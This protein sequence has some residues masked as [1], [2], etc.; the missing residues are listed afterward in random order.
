MT[1]GDVLSL[2]ARDFPDI[3]ISKIRFLEDQGLVEPDRTPSGYRK[4]T[5]EHVERLRSVLTLQR[6]HFLPLR[7]IRDLLSSAAVAPVL[8]VVGSGEP[9]A[10]EGQRRSATRRGP[11][12]RAWLI[13]EAGCDDVMLAEL[14]E[15]G[16]VDGSR[17][18]GFDGDD[19][20]ALRAAMTLASVGLRPRHLRFVRVAAEREAALVD[21]AVAAMP[22]TSS[23]ASTGEVRR[24]LAAALLRM[25]AALVA[26]R[27]GR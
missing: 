7:V 10:H 20:E 5:A 24:E 21:Q 4:F 16:L 25:H 14:E 19:V 13:A 23:A 12:D 17:P 22:S 8:H 11:H 3:T 27:L 1:I 6:D 9:G 15:H 18:G 26:Q 2:L